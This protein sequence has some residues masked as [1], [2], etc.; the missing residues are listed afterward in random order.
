MEY[1]FII[2]N[3]SLLIIPYSLLFVK[4]SLVVIGKSNLLLVVAG[5]KQVLV[6]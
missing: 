1:Y 2:L 3:G 6:V 5:E 4:S